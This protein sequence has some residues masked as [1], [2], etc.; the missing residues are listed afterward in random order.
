VSDTIIITKG[1]IT[2]TLTK[3]HASYWGGTNYY[4]AKKAVSAT[5]FKLSINKKGTPIV[6]ES[7][8]STQFTSV[9]P[10]PTEESWSNGWTVSE[11]S[12]GAQGDPHIKPFFG[13]DYTI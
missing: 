12:A 11:P 3:S 4:I 6:V 5:E 2:D 10:D 7:L 13:K 8:G 9:I 1:E